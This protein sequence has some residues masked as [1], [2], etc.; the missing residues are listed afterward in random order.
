MPICQNHKIFVQTPTNFCLHHVCGFNLTL[1]NKH[2]VIPK[3]KRTWEI[4]TFS[5]FP[6]TELEL[7]IGCGIQT[8]V[9]AFY[10][11]I[12]SMILSTGIMVS[13]RS[14]FMSMFFLHERL[15]LIFKQWNY[16]SFHRLRWRCGLNSWENM[17]I[18]SYA[19]ALGLVLKWVGEIRRPYF[20]VISLKLEDN[21]FQLLA[22]CAFYFPI[23]QY[24]WCWRS[25]C[26]WRGA[27]TRQPRRLVFD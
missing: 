12:D 4:T 16:R 18:W 13:T 25:E 2:N 14:I 27:Q 23:I 22:Y 10:S 21:S 15:L 17:F 24:F 6:Y 3:L 5:N 8:R 1:H 19:T 11:V 7:R 26:L 20:V 9:N